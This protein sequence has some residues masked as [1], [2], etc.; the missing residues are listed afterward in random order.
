MK[1]RKC[2]KLNYS[3]NIRVCG[4]EGTGD[5]KDSRVLSLTS[6]SNPFWCAVDFA[7]DT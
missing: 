2:F 7:K 3:D 5:F 4:N 1:M 6:T